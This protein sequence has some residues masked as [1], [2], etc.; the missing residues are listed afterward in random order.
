LS[1]HRS[2]LP[3]AVRHATSLLARVTD[4]FSAWASH[5]AAVKKH[6]TSIREILVVRRRLDRLVRAHLD[7]LFAYNTVLPQGQPKRT[8]AATELY[9]NRTFA[10]ILHAPIPDHLDHPDP[11]IDNADFGPLFDAFWASQD[12]GHDRRRAVLTGTLPPG[13]SLDSA[14]VYFKCSRC[15]P[16]WNDVFSLPDALRH[17]CYTYTLPETDRLRIILKGTTDV[18]PWNH[19]NVL[20]Y[21]A[22]AAKVATRLILMSGRDPKT[23]SL[24]EF[25]EKGPWVSFR[26]VRGRWGWNPSGIPLDEAVGLYCSFHGLYPFSLCVSG[27]GACAKT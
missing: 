8:S 25:L 27:A 21:D 26:C 24:A 20:A 4:H 22:S 1:T 18:V 12:P 5:A 13:V 15:H 6:V 17:Q 9:T 2:L 23:A 14:T 3:T 10:K 11:A 19:D 7:Y 16:R